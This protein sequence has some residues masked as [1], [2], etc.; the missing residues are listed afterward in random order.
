MSKSVEAFLSAEEEQMVIEQIQKLE[1]ATSGEIRVHLEPNCKGNIL[2]R[3]YEVFHYL[4]MDQ[5]KLANGVLIYVAV[6]DHKFAIY[7]DVGID[8]VVP[9]DFWESTKETI[10]LKFIEGKFAQGLIDGIQLAGAELQAYF[11]WDTNDTNE[12]SDEISKG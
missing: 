7:G 4:K 3:A 2:E 9:D 11:P 10:R 1:K 8:K 12:L 6:L 5:T